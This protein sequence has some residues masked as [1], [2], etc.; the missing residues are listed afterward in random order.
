MSAAQVETR[1]R[2]HGRRRGASGP[3]F[4]CFDEED[5]VR[6]ELRPRRTVLTTVSEVSEVLRRRWTVE[7]RG[8][9][10]LTPIEPHFGADPDV[11]HGHVLVVRDR[12]TQRFM[13]TNLVTA[14]RVALGRV[15]REVAT[16]NG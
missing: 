16:L 14:G 15:A 13:L 3:W 9:I 4:A 7:D 5:A 1:L 10:R 8:A 2:R 12:V 6:V 11:E